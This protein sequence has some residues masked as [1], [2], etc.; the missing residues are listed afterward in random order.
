MRLSTGRVGAVDDREDDTSTTAR[1]ADTEKALR[2][3]GREM[4]WWQIELEHTTEALQRARRQRARLREQVDQMSDVLADTLSA[5]YWE[6]R[7]AAP[8]GVGR[9][10]GRAPA[11]PEADLVR[12]VEASDLFDGGW[13]LRSHAKA[14]RS[15]P[16]PRPALRTPR[17][18]QAPRPRPAVQHRRPPRAQHPEARDGD[19]PAL[20]HATRHG[21]LHESHD[22]P[23]AAASPAHDLHL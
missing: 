15:G 22:D 10:L 21:L 7:A 3:A 18:R 20:L 16:E 2:R 8:G 6:T 14:V 4:K 13:Y 19:L 1:L 12:E 23:D 5:R 9:L 17:Q 11:D